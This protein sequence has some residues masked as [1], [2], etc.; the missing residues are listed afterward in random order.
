L[1]MHYGWAL[2]QVFDNQALDP[3]NRVSPKRALILEEDLHVAP[4]FFDYFTATAPL[5]DRDSSLLAV[6]AFNDNG[7]KNFVHRPERILR[8]DFFPGLGWMMTRKLWDYELA[9]KWPN[10]Y[11]D[12]WLREP[13]QRQGRHILRPEISRTFHFG[14]EGGTSGNQFGHLLQNILLNPTPVEWKE[15]DLSYLQPEVFDKYYWKMIQQARHVNSVREALDL[16]HSM[17]VQLEYQSLN[18]F[19]WI[20]TDLK[21]MTDEK[22]GVPRTAYKGVVEIRPHGDEF[23]LF[24]TPPMSTLRAS[25]DAL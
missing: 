8:S 10:Q 1:A 20:A 7:Y 15:Q 2:K 11:W 3:G 22:A 16:S 13:A 23:I 9:I 21:I 19:K 5:L 4:D 25:F 17:N 18:D 12:D 14:F 24:I 6:S